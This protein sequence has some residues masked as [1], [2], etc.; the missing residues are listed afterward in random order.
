MAKDPKYGNA[1]IMR[2]INKIML[3]GKKRKAETCFYNALLSSSSKVKM[4]P[5][6]FIESVIDNVRPSLEIKARRVGG[7]NYHV[8]VPVDPIRQ[9]TLA[10]R[11]I[12]GAARGKS[13]ASFKDLLEKELLDAFKEEG[14]AI[15]KKQDV[16]KMAEANKAFAHFRW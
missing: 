14:E 2:F 13:G 8:P 10:V 16:E 4:E 15:K 12:V 11:W 9:E 3:H 6:E 1:I 5:V 7:A